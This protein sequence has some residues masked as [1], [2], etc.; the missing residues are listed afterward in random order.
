MAPS[1]GVGLVARIV[2]ALRL[3]PTLYREVTS[4]DAG[5]R[6]AVVMILIT[7]VI[8]GFQTIFVKS[9]SV[10][11]QSTRGAEDLDL[12]LL[13]ALFAVPAIAQIASWLIWAFGLWIIA[14]R[15]VPREHEVPYFGQVA[16]ALAF[17]QAPIVFAV[18]IAVLA[19]LFVGVVSALVL[20][21]IPEE[22]REGYPQL[23]VLGNSAAVWGI[24]GLVTAWVLVGTFV[25]TR[26]ALRLS[27][28][29]TLV[30]LL[31]VNLVGATLL[32]VIVVVLSGVAGREAVGLMEDWVGFRDDNPSAVDVAYRLDFNFGFLGLSDRTLYYL[33]RSLLHPFAGVSGA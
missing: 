24:G 33:S 18:V 27:N 11:Q 8:W 13:V 4:P 32:A 16:R 12:G 23:V 21:L 25:A 17:A 9:A 19:T 30:A 1:A 3:D 10:L 29:R 20:I 26:E 15:W 22:I 6:Q 28:G 31:T 14:T 7:S 2:R 5:N